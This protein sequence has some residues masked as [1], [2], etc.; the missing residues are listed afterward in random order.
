MKKAE[1]IALLAT[2]AVLAG[3]YIAWVERQER[4]G[5]PA[6]IPNSL[7]KNHTFTGICVSVF[8][9]W[10]AFNATEQLSSFYLQYLQKLSAIDTSVRFLPAPFGGVLA[11]I[12]AGLV[13]HRVRA[14]LAI[15]LAVVLSSLSPLLMAIVDP[16]W[17]YWTCIFWAMFMNAIGADTLFTIS[18]LL[19]TSLFP[20]RQQGVAGSVFNTIAQIGKSVGLA[21]SGAIASAVTAHSTVADKES[22]TALLEGYRASFWYC[23]ALYGATLIVTVWGLRMIGKVGVKKE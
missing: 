23:F 18:N 12:V 13:V 7:W 3:G 1:N 16:A 11:S 17:S 22:P 15:L 4:L 20:A 5:R 21:S 9:V 10:G 14:D 8:M 19:I 2:S 6:V